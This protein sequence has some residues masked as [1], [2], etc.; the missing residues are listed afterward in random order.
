MRHQR[1]Q[2]FTAF[3][4]LLLTFA[5]SRTVRAQDDLGEVVAPQ[6]VSAELVQARLQ[7]LETA[8][9]LEESQRT[10]AIDA[11]KQ[12]LTELE[13]KKMLDAKLAKYEEDISAIPNRIEEQK[14]KVADLPKEAQIEFR[15][16]PSLDDAQELEQLE[17]TLRTKRQELDDAKKT[18][19][20]LQD[21][22]KRR[23]DRRAEIPKALSLLDEKIASLAKEQTTGSGIP[24]LDEANKHLSQIRQ[25]NAKREGEVLK[26]ESE[27]YDKA[28]ELL[29]LRQELAKRNVSL[30]E[31]QAQLWENEVNTFRQEL[32]KKQ[33]EQAAAQATK[34]PEEL[35]KLA[36]ANSALTQKRQELDEKIKAARAQLLETAKRYDQLDDQFDRVQRQVDDQLG[37]TE[38]IGNLL[39]KQRSELP[40]VRKLRANIRERQRLIY[41]IRFK[42]FENEEQLLDFSDFDNRVASEIDAIAAMPTVSQDR[43]EQL[44]PQI[45]QL[46]KN[47]Q[48]YLEGLRTDY[49][50]YLD[51]LIKLDVQEEAL[52]GLSER[53]GAYID[54]RILW[55]RSTQPA[56]VSDLPNAG[57]AF[58][59][60]LTGNRW[61][62]VGR[63]LLAQLNQQRLLNA[64]VILVFI[65]LAGYRVK[66]RRR[67]RALGESADATTCRDFSITLWSLLFTLGLTVLFPAVLIW[68]AWNLAS[69]PDGV[70]LARP[71]GQACQVAAY[72]LFPLLLWQGVVRRYGLAQSHFEWSEHVLGVVR[73]NLRWLVI[74]V[75]PAVAVFHIFHTLEHPVWEKSAARL[76]FLV[77]ACALTL[78]LQ[79]VLSPQRGIF[80]EYLALNHDGWFERLRFV[81]YSLL[82]VVPVAILILAFAGYQYTASELMSRFYMSL[83]FASGVYLLGALGQRWI[84][85]KRRALAIEQARQR[86]TA[87]AAETES[88]EPAGGVTISET[89]DLGAVNA[90]TQRLL[91]SFEIAIALIGL[92]FIWIGVLPALAKL[93]E[94]GLWETAVEIRQQAPATSEEASAVS[95]SVTVGTTTEYRWITLGNLF[96]SVVIALLTIVAVFNI[97][98]LLEIAILQKLPLDAS[99]RYAITTVTRYFIIVMGTIL[100]FGSIGIGWSK[101]QWLVAALSLGLAFGLQEIFAN[102]VSGLILLFERPLRAGDI[103]TVG[104]VSGTVV[105][106]KTRA[107]MIRDW[108][109]KE[110]VVPNKEFITGRLLNWTLSDTVNRV[111]IPVGIA[112][113]S[114]VTLARQIILDVA[115]EHPLV[116]DDPAPT[117]T[118]DLFADSALNFT[119]RAFLADLSCRLATIHELHEAIHE[120]LHAAG[121]EIAFP[122]RDLHIR[123][124]EAPFTLTDQSNGKL[125]AADGNSRS[126]EKTA[127]EERSRET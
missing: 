33:K 6:P 96:R 34:V 40:N 100:A 122:Q 57:R 97:P 74:T 99:L 113:G 78:F 63:E 92:Y 76:S 86:A 73:R 81:W 10:K 42:E 127:R 17:S 36:N 26:K 69:L 20:T 44:R 95:D 39:R 68:L 114:D 124:V 12:I 72:V 82:V 87:Q 16:D 60:L 29:P 116:L 110:L 85:L 115:N 108:D 80:R 109:R 84:K 14:K 118:F 35:T 75:V 5:A 31:Q 112:Y 104:D 102:F 50:S 101:V 121:I 89:V 43:A 126:T 125:L 3:L 119:L 54:E 65:S 64:L 4:L 77:A 90:Q 71:L 13:A 83:A 18:L 2:R 28:V 41:E 120:R 8:T 79:R 32:I 117:V 52:T 11:Y 45:Q 47:K 88:V 9:E 38:A 67:I 27:L 48:E 53:Y 15:P 24:Q 30:L 59:W 107:T 21:E 61:W 98:G 37:V 55:I 70:E 49:K 46:L 93:D 103:V 23:S 66:F 7:A 111:V 51:A 105:Q 62:E 22:P 123:S 91:W 19:A 1:A 106:I 94:I 25:S 58:A 56:S